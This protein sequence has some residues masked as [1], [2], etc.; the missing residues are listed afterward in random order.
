MNKFGLDG[1]MLPPDVEMLG[2]ETVHS[3][4]FDLE[5]IAEFDLYEELIGVGYSPP[6]LGAKRTWDKSWTNEGSSRIVIDGTEEEPH[7]G[8]FVSAKYHPNGDHLQRR[9]QRD[10]ALSVAVDTSLAELAHVFKGHTMQPYTGKE[11]HADSS[12]TSR[13]RAGLGAA[14]TFVQAYLPK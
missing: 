4:R 1:R 10:Q 3:D 14:K 5:L 9:N 11:S 7:Y 6:V 2:A 8:I 12:L 13:V